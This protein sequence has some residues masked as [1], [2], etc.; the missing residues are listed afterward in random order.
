MRITVD[1]DTKN[2]LVL[3]NSL[4]RGLILLRKIPFIE[5]SNRG[6]HLIWHGVDMPES[7]TYKY[8]LLIG[9]DENRVRLDMISE[10]R[11]KQVLF[12]HKTFI[13]LTSI[14]TYE[15]GV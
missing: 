4:L 6:F 13:D 14:K 5:E 9:D 11:I 2:P 3:F 7:D 10:K 15:R 12:T 8:R 1:I